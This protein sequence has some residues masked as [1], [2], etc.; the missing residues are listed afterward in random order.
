MGKKHLNEI[1]NILSHQGNE[2]QNDYEI[3]RT[4]KLLRSITQVTAYGGINVK[5][6]E[7][8]SIVGGSTNFYRHY[9][10]QY[11]ASSEN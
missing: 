1:F 9:R 10:N 3:L 7:H 2:N 5:Q 8:A 4:V 11:G 6:K